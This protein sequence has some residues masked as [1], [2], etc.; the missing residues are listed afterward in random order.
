M[1][2]ASQFCE[3]EIRLGM[4]ALGDVRHGVERDVVGIVDE[5][6]VIEAVVAGEGDGFLGDAFLKAAVAVERDDVVIEDRVLGGVEAGGGAF[7][8]ERVADGI[9]D[10]LAERAGGGLDARGFMKL[11]VAGSDRVELAEIFHIVL[12]NRVAGKVQPAV[13]E[14]RAVAGGED[15]TVAV[16]PFRRVRAVA[17]RFA[18]EH[19]TDFGAA[20]RQA[21]VA[22][23]AG[24]DGIHGEATGFVGGLGKQGGIHGNGVRGRFLRRR[25]RTA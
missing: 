9:A 23:I 4:F 25:A 21:E 1:V 16:Q 10:A 7:S 2:T 18:E 15:E 11:R 6:Q 12:G 8:G 13:E 20:E 5:D 3:S 19:G 22:G 14:H 17:H 24:V